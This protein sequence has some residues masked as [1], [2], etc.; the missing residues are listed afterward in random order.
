MVFLV[1]GHL[2]ALASPWFYASRSAFSRR[3]RPLQHTRQ[4]PHYHRAAC[5]DSE[6]LQ[7]LV[8]NKPQPWVYKLV[9]EL[10]Q[11]KSG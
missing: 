11:A 6:A 10:G 9:H 5:N 3:I 8:E 4:L 1:V 7:P 2:G